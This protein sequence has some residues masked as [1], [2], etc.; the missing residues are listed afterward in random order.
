MMILIDGRTVERRFGGRTLA[1]YRPRQF[2]EPEIV[3]ASARADESGEAKWRVVDM[4]I[5]FAA[6]G[7]A[8]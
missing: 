5:A 4:M 3:A 2:I 7:R 8:E 1:Y 6:A